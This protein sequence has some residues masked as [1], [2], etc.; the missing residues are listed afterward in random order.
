M[1]IFQEFED[2]FVLTFLVC[3][4]TFHVS[5]CHLILTPPLLPHPTRVSTPA[6][7]QDVLPPFR[8][9]QQREP[10]SGRQWGRADARLDQGWGDLNLIIIDH[11]M[12][13]EFT[14]RN[15][16]KTWVQKD[17][18]FDETNPISRNRKSFCRAEVSL[19]SIVEF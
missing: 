13:P 19:N 1:T 10:G 2:L 15:F 11:S 16:D 8:R 14:N 7:R 9:R 3:F 6:P 17:A 5:F 12:K 4:P 18:D